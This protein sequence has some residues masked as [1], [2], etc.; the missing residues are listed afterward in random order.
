MIFI[1]GR[2]LWE[3]RPHPSAYD[4]LS[5]WN[6]W[7]EWLC[8]GFEIVEPSLRKNWRSREHSFSSPHIS[9]SN[10]SSQRHSFTYL[11]YFEMGRFKQA[12]TFYLMLYHTLLL[13]FR[14]SIVPNFQLVRKLLISLG[15]MRDFPSNVVFSAESM[16]S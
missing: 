10:S 1:E 14:C 12:F 9:S 13:S 15:D 8:F 4:M 11:F 6:Y 16:E 5:D 3:Q 2:M 7:W